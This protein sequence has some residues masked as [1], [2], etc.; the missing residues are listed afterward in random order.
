MSN[1]NT[2]Y[3]FQFR[4]EYT[5]G[6]QGVMVVHDE[7]AQIFWD[8]DWCYRESDYNANLDGGHYADANGG[9]IDNDELLEML[10]EDTNVDVIDD[11][12]IRAY[13]NQLKAAFRAGPQPP[14][15]THVVDIREAGKLGLLKS[16]PHK[17][18]LLVE[19]ESEPTMMWSWDYDMISP[20]LC[21]ECIEDG[22]DVEVDGCCPHGKP[23]YTLKAGIA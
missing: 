17:I 9:H 15:I 3:K 18:V 22:H 4:P 19:G 14:E 6:G 13:R 5:K 8:G 12:S 16:D 21:A 7:E 1:R 11:I 23:A 10:L 20:P 2:S